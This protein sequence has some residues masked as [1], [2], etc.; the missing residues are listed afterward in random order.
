[1]TDQHIPDLGAQ[2]PE[3]RN[4]PVAWENDEETDA[5]REQEPGAPV[6]Y[7]NE[8]AYDDGTVVKSGTALLR[9]SYGI[10]FPVASS[11]PDNP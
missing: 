6:C 11:D 10:W 9:C 3:L 8:N 1:M 5:L 7:F 4:S 2:D